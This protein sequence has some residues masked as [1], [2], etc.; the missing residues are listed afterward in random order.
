MLGWFTRHAVFDPPDANGLAG[1]FG[2]EIAIQSERRSV[3]PRH[4]RCTCG[5][6]THGSSNRPSIRA[7]YAESAT[8]IVTHSV[9]AEMMCSKVRRLLAK[10]DFPPNAEEEAVQLVLEQTEL[11][12]DEMADR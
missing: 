6:N 5:A 3:H 7:G 11:V 2:P 12:A 4:D 10:Y 8:A 1:S 9:P